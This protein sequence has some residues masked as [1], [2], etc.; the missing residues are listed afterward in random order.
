LLK[1]FQHST[2]FQQLLKSNFGGTP[3]RFH[4]SWLRGLA[5]LNNSAGL[6]FPHVP[7]LVVFNDTVYITN[8]TYA[9][10]ADNVCKGQVIMANLASDQGEQTEDPTETPITPTEAPADSGSNPPVAQ[11]TDPTES[12]MES[13][14]VPTSGEMRSS[15]GIVAGVL[16]LFIVLGMNV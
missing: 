7:G 3:V 16:V 10:G 5:T 12:P 15:L 1:L 6:G 9:G 8:D 14:E 4:K 11:P 13:T 2:N